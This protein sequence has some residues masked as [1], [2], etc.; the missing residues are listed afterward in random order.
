M[1]YSSVTMTFLK[2]LRT[3]RRQASSSS[4]VSYRCAWRSMEH[5]SFTVSREQSSCSHHC[6][7]RCTWY[8]W[9]IANKLCNDTPSAEAEALLLASL[10]SLSSQSCGDGD[11]FREMHPKSSV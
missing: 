9:L 11:C 1:Q 7:K 5:T 4:G 8:L 2:L 6:C 10:P 3:K